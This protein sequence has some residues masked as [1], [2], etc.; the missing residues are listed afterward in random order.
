M[1]FLTLFPGHTI[2]GDSYTIRGVIISIT[3]NVYN[4]NHEEHITYKNIYIY[5]IG[6]MGPKIKPWGTSY[7]M[8]LQRV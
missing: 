7:L 1:P 6:K 2:K 3:C 4:I 5:I 8:S